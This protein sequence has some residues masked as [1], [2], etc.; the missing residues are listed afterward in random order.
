MN[1]L[2]SLLVPLSQSRMIV[3]RSCVA[4]VIGFTPQAPVSSRPDWFLGTLEWSGRQV[5]VVSFDRLCGLDIPRPSARCR[6]VVMRGLSGV[7][8]A[9]HLAIVTD[10]F[11]QLV[12]VN[13]AVLEPDRSTEWP[14]DSPVICQPRMI[15]Q[16]PV[17]PDLERLERMTADVIGVAA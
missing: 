17:I 13:A 10:G 6:V 1:E 12:R 3:P 16:R 9:G 7:L 14:D 2:Y 11:P 15:N 8:E 4:E 5:P